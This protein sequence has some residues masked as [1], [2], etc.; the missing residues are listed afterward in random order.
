MRT[1]IDFC[2]TFLVVFVGMNLLLIRTSSADEWPGWL[3]PK[4]DG[5]VA[6]FKPPAQWPKSLSQRWR[7]EVGTGYGSPLVQDGHVYHHARQGEEEVVWCLDLKTGDVK[8]RK[9]YAL[10]FKV[11]GGAEF[12]VAMDRGT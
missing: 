9:S 11:G 10:P 7:V 5:W 12:Q 8:W 1:L 2:R 4:R 6:G 3:G